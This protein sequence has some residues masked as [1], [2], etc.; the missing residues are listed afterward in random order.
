M[1][2]LCAY[3]MFYVTGSGAIIFGLLAFF[4]V[5]G[6][7][8]ILMENIRFND[9][10]LPIEEKGIKTRVIGQYIIAALADL[11]M[12]IL[13][14]ICIAKGKPKANTVESIFEKK[15]PSSSNRVTK[16]KGLLSDEILEP[17]MD[18]NDINNDEGEINTGMGMGGAINDYNTN[19][20]D[21]NSQ[22]MGERDI[23]LGA[24]NGSNR[25]SQVL[26]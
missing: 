19:T 14:M 17:L 13:F 5:A 22:A 4:T 12:A 24:I 26:G 9:Q 1:A 21:N 6:N 16:T 7:P 25:G 8:V 2:G 15:K 20:E 3:T 11:A 18:Q 10:N 23:P